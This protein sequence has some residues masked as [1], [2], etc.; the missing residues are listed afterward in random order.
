MMQRLCRRY[1][2]KTL[3]QSDSWEMTSEQISNKVELRV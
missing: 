1:I 3:Q 2:Y